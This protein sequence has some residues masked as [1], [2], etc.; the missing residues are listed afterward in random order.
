MRSRRVAMQFSFETEGLRTLT[1]KPAMSEPTVSQENLGFIATCQRW[2]THEAT[3]RRIA[4]R[5]SPL[6]LVKHEVDF[7]FRGNLFK[8]P[9]RGAGQLRK[10]QRAR[11]G[12]V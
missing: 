10:G 8:R 7:F 4:E 2:P 9:A 1:H 12:L 3:L 5:L 11:P 6:V